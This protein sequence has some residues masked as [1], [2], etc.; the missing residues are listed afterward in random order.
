V[1]RTGLLE[2]CWQGLGSGAGGC[3]G[4]TGAGGRDSSRFADKKR[5]SATGDGLRFFSTPPPLPT[6]VGG[7]S[8]GGLAPHQDN[9][10]TPKGVA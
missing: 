10:M 6:I 9:P 5:T 7:Q 2:L 1:L 8:I 3:R 4:E